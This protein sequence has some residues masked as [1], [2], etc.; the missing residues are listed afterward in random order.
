[1]KRIGAKVFSKISSFS[2]QKGTKGYK[3][4]KVIYSILKREH[5]RV[6]NVKCKHFGTLI[7]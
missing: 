3:I 5:D 2:I 4:G 6:M 1:M 7:M